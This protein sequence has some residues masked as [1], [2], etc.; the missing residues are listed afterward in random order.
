MDARVKKAMINEIHKTSAQA[1]ARMRGK[2]SSAHMRMAVGTVSFNN[3]ADGAV[4]RGGGNAVFAGAEFGGRKRR[5]TYAMRRG[6]T[7]FVMHRRRTTMQFLTHL[8][9]RGYFFWP[10][11][12]EK[13]TGI[14]RRTQMAIE[15]EVNR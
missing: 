11:I 6:G 15:A 9:K 8:G 7:A 10:S 4:I 2:A 3:T 1:V 5:R 12:R 13:F 14:A